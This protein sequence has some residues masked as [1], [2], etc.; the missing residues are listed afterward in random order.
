MLSPSCGASNSKFESPTDA[1]A[2]RKEKGTSRPRTVVAAGSI[3]QTPHGPIPDS[4]SA[5][6]VLFHVVHDEAGVMERTRLCDFHPCLQVEGRRLSP[7]AH[8]ATSLKSLKPWIWVA[9]T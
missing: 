9:T 5:A 6:A 3:V 4:P 2:I 7:V 1:N 8:G